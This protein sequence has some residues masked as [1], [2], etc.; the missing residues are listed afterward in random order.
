MDLSSTQAIE[1]T[2]T[3]ACSTY[4]AIRAMA[5]FQR[6]R[7][8]DDPWAN[9]WQIS[10]VAI[11]AAVRAALPHFRKEGDK[12]IVIVSSSAARFVA[13]E[14]DA[15]YHSTRAAQ[16]GLM[17]YLAVR[18]GPAGIRVNSVSP[19]TVVKSENADH[20]SS[21]PELANRF[22][23]AAALRR[24]GHSREVAAAAHFLC[25]SEAS[26]VTGHELVCDGGASLVSAESRPNDSFTQ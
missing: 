10:V 3:D 5:F 23:S 21:R 15:A 6:F 14:Q 24:M 12:A 17:R 4:G 25:S 11:E 7:G 16:L 26:W 18:L 19:G 13:T 20:F 9:H 22:A 1:E 8:K 2:F